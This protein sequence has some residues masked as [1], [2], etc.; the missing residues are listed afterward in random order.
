MTV[1]QLYVFRDVKNIRTRGYPRIKPATDRKQI[2]KIDT[3]YP[4]VRVFLIP[5][6]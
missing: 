3:R 6:C 2:L 1:I 4:W 5:A